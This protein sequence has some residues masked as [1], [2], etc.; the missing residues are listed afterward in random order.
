MSKEE[1]P[2][3]NIK[4]LFSNKNNYEIPIYQRNYAWGGNEIRQLIVDIKDKSVK[5]KENKENK[6]YYI[7]TLIVNKKEKDNKVIYEVIDGQQR[8][9]TLSILLSVIKNE[10]KNIDISWYQQNLLSF[11]SRP[12]STKTLDNIFNGKTDNI[13]NN[14]DSIISGYEICKNELSK[15][16]NIKI[17]DFC[18]YLFNKVK[19]LQIEVL[20]NTDLN[21]YFEIMNTRGKQLEPVD[22]LKARCLSIL[23]NN[24]DSS[25]FT[26]IWE[27]CSNMEKYIQYGFNTELRKSIFKDNL[28]ELISE[29][30]L[31]ELHSK[32]D[33]TNYTLEPKSIND[34]L[35][36]PKNI[37]TA[38]E[39][40][41][42]AK[43]ERFNS[44]IDFPNFLLHILK[45]QE[46]KE[47]K[48]T[49]SLNDK[50]LLNT[51]S[52][53]DSVKKFGY[54][55]L[56]GRFLFDKYI[57]K[58]EFTDKGEFWGLKELAQYDSSINYRATTFG[59]DKDED[60][61][62][63]VML[64]SMFHVS[65]PTNIYKNWLYDTL[66]FLFNKE[67][68]LTEGI[69]ISD[70]KNKLECLASKYYT[71]WKNKDGNNLDSGTKVLHFVFNYLDYLLWRDYHTKEYRYTKAENKRIG[72]FNFTTRNSVEHYYPQNPMEGY[73]RL[74][75]VV[76]N[77]GNICLISRSRNS[78]LNHNNPEGKKAHYIK[79]KTIDS[80][81]Q[82]IMFTYDKWDTDKILAHGKRM[83]ELLEKESSCILKKCN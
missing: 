20:P 62:N 9:T 72:D 63:I 12:N 4:D 49:I 54:N 59:D 45:I 74:D 41:E 8:L 51:F 33:N 37:D 71:E 5:N 30:E 43:A 55:L 14:S 29:E 15:L 11:A 31:Y 80:I 76:N 34:L 44:I 28:N 39:N 48:D 38:K 83:K 73:E 35:Q 36:E 70:Y 26:L 82:D 16:E 57:I 75:E 42:G 25:I 10:Y 3:Y 58:K 52:K 13:E 65:Y 77:F 64:L 61:T 27:A 19:I 18:E 21:H 56:K 22:I 81:K 50:D 68:I 67:T 40:E 46:E 69:K 23:G 60:N 32:S 78:Q 79:S 66:R 1:L 2:F 6:D 53:F 7:G 24:K 17:Q 47:D